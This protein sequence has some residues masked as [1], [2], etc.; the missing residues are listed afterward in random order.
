MASVESHEY[1]QYTNLSEAKFIFI[2]LLSRFGM[3]FV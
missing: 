2:L 3:M 1:I